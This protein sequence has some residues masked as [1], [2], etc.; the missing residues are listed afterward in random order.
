MGGISLAIRNTTGN[1]PTGYFSDLR[2]PAQPRAATAAAAI[3]EEA[4]TQVWNPQFIAGMQ[5]EG[6]SAAASLTEN[7]RNLYAWNV[8]QPAVISETLWDETFEVYIDDK[9]GLDL[10]A[11]FEDINPAAL[12]DMTAIMLET[13]RKGMW[14]P[15]DDVLQ[16][17]A[18]LHAELVARHGAGC[19]YETCGNA[20]LHEFLAD[21]LSAPGSE[22]APEVAESY[23]ASLAD[24]LKSSQPLPE[25]EG[26]ELEEKRTIVETLL[27]E[28]SP[29]ATALLASL[30][31]AATVLLVLAGLIRATPLA[32]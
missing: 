7:V 24:A 2:D 1:D 27:S 9:H 21:A 3:R 31:V 22:T 19:S 29:L 32:A 10:Q 13:I 12:Q 4:R 15:S 16:R 6:P 20:K 28:T 14:T 30:I 18:E 8:M 25:V 26:L 5:S 23:H 17:L 11:Y